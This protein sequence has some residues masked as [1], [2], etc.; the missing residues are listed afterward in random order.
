LVCSKRIKRTL[1]AEKVQFLYS[2]LLMMLVQEM[3]CLLLRQ[4]KNG[5]L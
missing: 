3:V 2:I 5:N 1:L 4:F